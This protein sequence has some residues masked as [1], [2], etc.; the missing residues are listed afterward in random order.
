MG[1]GPDERHTLCCL[2]T[3]QAWQLAYRP[4]DTQIKERGDASC[5]SM[6]L[7]L[8][9][10]RLKIIKGR[11]PSSQFHSF[12][13]SRRSRGDA[14]HES[15]GKLLVFREEPVTRMNLRRGRAELRR[16]SPAGGA[17]SCSHDTY[18]LCSGGSDGLH[19]GVHVEVALTGGGGANAEG[20]VCH[21]DVDLEWEKLDWADV[22]TGGDGWNDG[23][24]FCC[25]FNY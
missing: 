21:L 8:V 10:M 12:P 22:S 6:L 13:Q 16:S 11:W 18:G 3:N 1:V 17:S 15:L 19:D 24:Y 5:C 9:M 2:V 23:C 20:L 25:F 14:T 7:G 4:S